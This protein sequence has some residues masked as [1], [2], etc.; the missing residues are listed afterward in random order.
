MSVPHNF[1][2][3]EKVNPFLESLDVG[4][5]LNKPKAQLEDSL[6]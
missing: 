5:L 3:E 1:F 6:I 4:A 2:G